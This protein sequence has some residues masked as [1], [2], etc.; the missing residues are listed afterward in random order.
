[1]A[2]LVVGAAAELVVGASAAV[3]AEE[4]LDDELPQPASASRAAASTSAEIEN[5]GRFVTWPAAWN[6]T[7]NP[8][9]VGVV[10]C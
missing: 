2:E 8:P 9:L 1:M 6:L 3:L 4:E 10:G 5:T 7:S